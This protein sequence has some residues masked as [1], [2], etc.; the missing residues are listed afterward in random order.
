[1]GPSPLLE[2]FKRGEAARDVRMLAAQGV[3][4]PRAHE[5]LSILALLVDD[6][7]PEIRATAEAT[8]ASIPAAAIAAFLGRSD[9]PIGL[10][11]F[12]GDRGIFPAEIGAV[13]D[14]TEAPLVEAGDP[15][16]FTDDADRESVGQKLATMN[17]PDKLKAAIKGS[18]EMR[19]ILVRDPNK[20]ICAAVMSSPKL[21]E[22][23]VEGISRMAS[24]SEDVLRIIG[25][26]R[27]WMK[28][29]KIASGLTRNPKT[30][31]AM[32]LNIM[33]RLNNKDLSTLAVDRNVPEQLRIA[34]KK[35]LASD[36]IG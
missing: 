31:I 12:F 27:G 21:T 23:E 28:N 15:D 11:E 34:A 14:E 4:A 32:S 6:A 35:K 2:F 17:M 3:L 16:E 5:Q 19:A 13:L 10:R 9:A 7:D 24:V 26:N 18:K 30:P 22:Q 25:A 8:L 20:M 1:M 29:Y 36:R 33:H